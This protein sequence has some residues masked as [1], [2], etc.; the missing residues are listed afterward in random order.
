VWFQRAREDPESKYHDYYL[1]SSHPEAAYQTV[2][3][4]PD[5][6]DGVWSYDDATYKH[7]FHQ[8]YSHQPDLNV[9]HPAVQEEIF[10][11]LRFWIQQGADGF[12]IDAAHPMQLPKGHHGHT[13]DDP[14]GLFKRMRRVVREE[15]GDAILLA[16]ADDEP[17]HLDHYFGDGEAFDLLFNFVLNV[18]LTYGVGVEDTWPLYRAEEVLPDIDGLGQWATFL[19][20]HDEWNLLKLPDETIEH[21]RE[22]FGDDDGDSWIFDRG[23]RLRLADL[24]DADHDRIELAHSLLLSMPGTPVLLSGDE[25]GMGADLSL[26]ERESVRTPMQ[27]DDSK[28]AGFSSTDPSDLYNPVVDEG[29]FSYEQVNVADQRDDPD[30]LLSGVQ[31]LVS[32]RDDYPGINDGDYTIVDSGHKDVFLHRIDTAERVLFCAHNLADEYREP[33]CG[34]EMPDTA[35][36]KVIG[37]GGYHV[38]DGGV[39]FLLDPGDYVWL[40][41]ER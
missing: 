28:N 39:T 25:I 37:T 18:H 3:I 32:A 16:E 40:D 38:E 1:W 8:F 34:F 27:W 36:E 6:E 20:N 29:R 41:A 9:A 31:Q 14:M 11:V 15:Q 30:S 24:Y 5:R 2:N 26:P 10:D 23:H 21:A 19:R 17:R 35:T 22:Y 33:V 13:L 12:R 4:F 7:Y